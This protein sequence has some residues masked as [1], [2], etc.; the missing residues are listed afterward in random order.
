MGRTE[1]E[2]EEEE[3]DKVKTS[4]DCSL[5]PAFS[6]R[7]SAEIFFLPLPARDVFFAC[8][9]MISRFVVLFYSIDNEDGVEKPRRMCGGGACMSGDELFA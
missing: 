5:S 9:A 3:E 7:A 8:P 6:P 4:H 1:E 2:E